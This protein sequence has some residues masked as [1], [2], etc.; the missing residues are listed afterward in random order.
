[1]RVG[2]RGGLGY[3]LGKKGMKSMPDEREYSAA[4]LKRGE[5]GF[6]ILETCIAMVIM[7]V[8]VLA[9]AALFAYSIGNNSS[10]GDRELAMAVAQQRIEQLRNVTFTDSTLTATVTS[11]TSTTLRRAGRDYTVVTTIADS[12]V[13]DG[14]PTQKTITV[15]VTPQ[16]SN[17]GPVMLRTQ[18]VT[19]LK[20]PY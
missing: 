12:N 18:R 7:L 5:D 4:H 11:G 16:G 6:T 8:A 9:S 10:A 20:G 13:I 2:A 1:V 17:L 15:Q 3:E 19:M 14:L